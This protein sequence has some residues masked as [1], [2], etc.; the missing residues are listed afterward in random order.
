M[1]IITKKLN[2]EHSDSE[3]VKDVPST[4]FV[5]YFIS[6][7]VHETGT[8][9]CSYTQISLVLKFAVLLSIFDVMC[10]YYYSDSLILQLLSSRVDGAIT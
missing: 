10:S 2:Y 8:F 4:Y 1:F 7:M 5:C 9:Q 3:I 6:E